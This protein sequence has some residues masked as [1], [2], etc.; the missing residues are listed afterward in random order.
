[1]GGGGFRWQ[2]TA[3][4]RNATLRG[5]SGQRRPVR[6]SDRCR[7]RC[8]SGTVAVVAGCC[9]SSPRRRRLA[10]VQQRPL[11]ADITGL[12]LKL[13]RPVAWL[14]AWRSR[15][16]DAPNRPLCRRW[17]ENETDAA[18]IVHRKTCG[19]RTVRLRVADAAAVPTGVRTDTGKGTRRRRRERGTQDTGTREG[20]ER[21]D[22]EAAGTKATR[23]P[24]ERSPRE[25]GDGAMA[26]GPR[27]RGRTGTRTTATP[28]PTG[29]EAVGGQSTD[30][31]TVRCRRT[32]DRI[33]RE[34][35]AAAGDRGN[36]GEATALFVVPPRSSV[37]I[38]GPR[39]PP[40]RLLLRRPRPRPRPRRLRLQR[41]HR[42]L[43]AS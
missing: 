36:G 1:V 12:S 35:R 13:R 23:E 42:L 20:G 10:Q 38:D 30:E 17:N 24:E 16:Q 4:Q 18:G 29:S 32:S 40:L 6:V 26:A 21:G 31:P 39:L 28:T 33:T 8:P 7:C 5:E 15:N 19:A 11:C 2:P 9:P 25:R 27:P 22:G 37:A 3:T 43:L 41:R 34:A 14:V